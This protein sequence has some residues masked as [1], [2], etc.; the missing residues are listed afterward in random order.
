MLRCEEYQY[1][2]CQKTSSL[3]FL[4]LLIHSTIQDSCLKKTFLK[5]NKKKPH[6]SLWTAQKVQ[7]KKNKPTQQNQLLNS[8]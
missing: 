6:N 5:Q 2:H 7:R 4:H 1:L 8:K 3:L